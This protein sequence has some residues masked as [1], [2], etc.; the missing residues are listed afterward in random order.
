MPRYGSLGRGL[1]R[2][3]QSALNIGLSIQRTLLTYAHSL[4]RY[5]PAMSNINKKSL[6][7]VP[8]SLGNAKATLAGV[9]TIQMIHDSRHWE[10]K[11]RFS[12]GYRSSC[13]RLL[14]G[15]LA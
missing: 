13:L 6:S 10:T 7:N 5:L 8:Y 14:S 2:S 15:S 12:P 11:V 1:D 4:P 9:A 3:S